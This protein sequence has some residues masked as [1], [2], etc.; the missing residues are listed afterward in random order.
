[1]SMNAEDV[2]RHVH[3][4]W[5]AVAPGWEEHADFIEAR[6]IDVTRR[7]LADTAPKPGEHVLELACG[8]GDVGLAAAGLVA[9]GEVIVSDV[10]AEMTAIATRRAQARGLDNVTG[11]T[12]GVEAIDAA[13]ATFD[14]AA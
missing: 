3:S 4:M 10:S 13:G 9:P 1:M 6:G 2:R 12:F 11:Q 8:T 14:V 5:S 7:L